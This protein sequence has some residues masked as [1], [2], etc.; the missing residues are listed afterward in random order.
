[1]KL[2][3]VRVISGVIC[4]TATAA[5]IVSAILASIGAVITF[6]LVASFAVLAMMV[7][8]TAVR[9][10]TEPRQADLAALSA[11]LETAINQVINSERRD[12]SDV[13]QVV[14]LAVKLG[15]AMGPVGSP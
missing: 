11:D 9:A 10:E 5:M 3:T 2:G 7:A 12:E 8:T 4:A 1:M 13:R 6:G 15:S 14:R